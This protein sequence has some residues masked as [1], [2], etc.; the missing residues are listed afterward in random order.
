MNLD[1]KNYFFNDLCHII[2]VIFFDILKTILNFKINI[3]VTIL[4]LF[5]NHI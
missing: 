4:T 5:E 2:R 3:M 1:T